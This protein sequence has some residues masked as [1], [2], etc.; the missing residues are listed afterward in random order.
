M[1]QGGLGQG[2]WGQR[3]A[4]DGM[5]DV[6][7]AKESRGSSS[8]STLI[9]QEEAAVQR[10]NARGEFGELKS[11]SGPVSSEVFSRP[12]GDVVVGV[13]LGNLQ[14]GSQTQASQGARAI[15]Y[16]DF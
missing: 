12:G 7:F 4:C 16:V 2:G 9:S 15:Y 1:G 13:K 14:K 10:M 3:I 11:G 8:Q 6:T 5:T